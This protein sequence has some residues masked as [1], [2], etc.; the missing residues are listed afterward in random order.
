[1]KDADNSKDSSTYSFVNTPAVFNISYISGSRV[2][3]NYAADNIDI[4]GAKLNQCIFAL[5]DTLHQLRLD[6]D[7][8]ND[9]PQIG[10]MGVSYDADESSVCPD[11]T[12][13]GRCTSNFTTPTVTDALFNAGYI[14]SHSYSLYLDD[15]ASRTGSMLWGGID[16]SKFYGELVTLGNVKSS[17]LNNQML[18]VKQNLYLTAVS[19]K[20]NGKSTTFTPGN[21]SVETILDS[22]NPGVGLPTSVF[23]QLRPYLPV[24][25]KF[26]GW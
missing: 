13:N 16:T 11:V 2:W 18:H 5:A 21:Y 20:T 23:K 12:S 22:G 3:G 15:V 8:G 7:D 25:E 4:A 10:L 19:G 17:L 9:S 6:D 1:M 26:P 14:K 24:V